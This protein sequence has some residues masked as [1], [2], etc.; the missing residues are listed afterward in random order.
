MTTATDDRDV[1]ARL[2]DETWLD[3]IARMNPTDIIQLTQVSTK[4]LKI[5]RDQGTW[6]N[7]IK[8][9]YDKYTDPTNSFKDLVQPKPTTPNMQEKTA[10]K[11]HG[12]SYKQNL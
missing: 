1:T 9:I 8:S 11:I 10:D 12:M 7:I 3:I 6:R 5:G 2:P 4:L